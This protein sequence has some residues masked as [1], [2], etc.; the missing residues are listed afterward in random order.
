MEAGGDVYV[1][2]SA[3][4]RL[5]V[6]GRN[7]GIHVARACGLA[8]PRHRPALRL[9]RICAVCGVPLSWNN[10][11]GDDTVTWVGFKLLHSSCKPDI[12]QR[13]ADWFIKWTQEGSKSSYVHMTSFEEGLD[14]VM[15]A[16]GDLVF[17]GGLSSAHSIVLRRSTRDDRCDASHRMFLSCC[18][19]HRL[20]FL[21]AAITPAR[22]FG[23]WRLHPG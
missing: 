11:A 12:S 4:G 18:I 17:A 8:C 3:L 23:Q 13:G 21:S 5:T 2:A 7:I 15:Y 22:K 9:L 10:T 6:H 14:R 20:R 1:R 19:T 16:V